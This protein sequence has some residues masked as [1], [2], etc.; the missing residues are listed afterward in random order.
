MAI[1]GT[2]NILSSQLEGMLAVA[3]LK[4]LLLSRKQ[5]QK[6]RRKP[7]CSRR[8]APAEV[9]TPKVVEVVPEGTDA[10]GCPR[11]TVLNALVPSARKRSL[12]RSLNLK[13]RERARST[14]L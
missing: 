2:A 4:S 9:I 7:N 13:S 1:F 12:K 14:T 3:F 5:S 11:F 6:V 10:P 8:I